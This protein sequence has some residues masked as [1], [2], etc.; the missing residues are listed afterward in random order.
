MA[1]RRIASHILLASERTDTRMF[2]VGTQWLND[3][4]FKT[5]AQIADIYENVTLDQVNAALQK[6][7]MQSP[8]TIAVGPKEDWLAV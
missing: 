4:T 5:P 3:Q 6:Y 1:K 2:S 8:M 7:H